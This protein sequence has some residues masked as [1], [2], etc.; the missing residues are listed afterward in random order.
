MKETPMSSFSVTGPGGEGKRVQHESTTPA[1]KAKRRRRRASRADGEAFKADVVA[2]LDVLAYYAD[3]G[4]TPFEKRPSRDGWIGCRNAKGD[5]VRVNVRTGYFKD[6]GSGR[7]AGSVFDFH[8]AAHGVKFPQALRE[9]A[10]RAGVRKT[11]G[12][13]PPAPPSPGRVNLERV[14]PAGPGSLPAQPAGGDTDVAR[15]ADDTGVAVWAL[16][17]FGVV[18]TQN[19]WNEAVWA[20]PEVDGD[21][22]VIGHATRALTEHV[23]D[24]KRKVA[25]GTLTGGHRGLTVPG[26]LPGRVD[27]LYAVEGLTDAAVLRSFGLHA[28]GRPSASDGTWHLVGLAKRL[29]VRELVLVGEHDRKPDGS[30]PGYDGPRGVAQEVERALPS[31]TVRLVLPPHGLKDARAWLRWEAIGRGWHDLPWCKPDDARLAF[32]G[33]LWERSVVEDGHGANLL[34]EAA[35]AAAAAAAR[36]GAATP[37][38]TTLPGEGVRGRSPREDHSR[39]VPDGAPRRAPTTRFL[40]M[41]LSPCASKSLQRCARH[42]IKAPPAPAL[43]SLREERSRSYRPC[44]ARFRAGLQNIA[45]PELFGA[46]AL[47]CRRWSCVACRPVLADGWDDHLTYPECGVVLFDRDDDGKRLVPAK[48]R[49]LWDG[50][51]GALKAATRRARAEGAEYAAVRGVYSALVVASAPFG[52]ARRVTAAAAAAAVRRAVAAL[53]EGRAESGRPVTTSRGWKMPDD[54]RNE[55]KFHRAI[56]PEEAEWLLARLW[57]DGIGGWYDA[58]GQWVFWN[59]P[60]EWSEARCLRFIR[61]GFTDLGEM[62]GSTAADDGEWEIVPGLVTEYVP[63]P[64]PEPEPAARRARA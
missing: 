42:E 57:M 28:V 30:W 32:L 49:W 64:E 43:F 20:S 40:E 18:Q 16:E 13:P 25:K 2:G 29:R 3:H 62:P 8:K 6:Y 1:G 38:K 24:G 15:L 10:E 17:T 50:P 37:S 60:P 45:D 46:K 54:V 53:R 44:P 39:P 58:K 23:E 19:T 5:S 27:R 33:R 63:E 7:K 9:L 21:G 22:R 41:W 51:A 36:A 35:A 47:R 56:R 59:F 14:G 34:R 31:V 4:V 55:W 11:R 48:Y 12:A 61:H 52:G 26:D